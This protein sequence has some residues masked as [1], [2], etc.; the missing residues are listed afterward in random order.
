MSEHKKCH[1]FYYGSCKGDCGNPHILARGTVPKGLE[2]TAKAERLNTRCLKDLV[3]MPARRGKRAK[4]LAV[5]PAPLGAE[6]PQ[7]TAASSEM[8]MSETGSFPEEVDLGEDRGANAVG[9]HDARRT[10]SVSVAS[11]CRSGSGGSQDDLGGGSAHLAHSVSSVATT[12]T[13]VFR[14]DPYCELSV[15]EKGSF[16]PSSEGYQTPRHD[17]EKGEGAAEEVDPGEDRGANAVGTHDARRTLSP[18]SVA[19]SCRSGSG[20]SQDD[21]GGGSAHLAHSVSSVATTPTGVFRH[22][23]YCELSGVFLYGGEEA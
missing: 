20:G 15:S 22:D 13:G 7:L 3:K 6:V 16:P 17:V 9:T 5:M 4:M 19:S 18:V 12:P 1:A 14:H 21:L 11:S 10:P 23:P 2:N 8:S